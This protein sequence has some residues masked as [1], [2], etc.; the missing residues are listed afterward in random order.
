MGKKKKD[1]SEL[2]RR[3]RHILEIVF[4]LG[5]AS[6]GDVLELLADPPAYD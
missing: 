2:G 1:T 5:E 6:V 3:E 4:Q